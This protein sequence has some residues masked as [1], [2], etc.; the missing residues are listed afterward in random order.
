[1]SFRNTHVA[2][3]SLVA[4]ALA[5]CRVER[6]DAH[7]SKSSA[8]PVIVRPAAPVERP[9]TIAAS[10]TVG[11]RASIDLTFQVPGM[12]MAVGVEE[13]ER[14]AAGE[15]VAVIDPTEYALA[16]EQAK[17]AY[18]TASGEAQKARVMRAA[19]GSAPNEFD[20]VVAA[21]AMTKI[22]AAR[23][24]KRLYDTQL[25]SP[26][27]GVVARRNAKPGEIVTAGMPAF[28]IVDLDVVHV[29]VGVSEADIE[30]V[31][32]GAAASITV[33]AL[34]SARFAGK[35]RLVGVAADPATGK[36]AVEI[37][38]PNPEHHLKVGMSANATISTTATATSVTVPRVALSQGSKGEPQVFVYSEAEHRVH[39]RG[40][41]L[42]S[43][44][45]SEVD[46]ASGLSAGEMIVVGSRVKLSDGMVVTMANQ[47]I[48][49]TAQAPAGDAGRQDGTP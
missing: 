17:V 26:L 11:P 13:G 43:H 14:V 34:D 21:E 23:A 47:P 35:V 41:A 32:M 27:A 22:V 30:N 25:A 20:Q 2:A 37:A 40:V 16:F 3:L 4:F 48:V 44:R 31:H 49:I 24:E 5:A 6:A 39:V 42:G 10:G 28:T 18:L 46:V 36:Y 33:P 29:R 45:G 15:L 12:V 8:V 7:P 9:T 1:M 19:D 38:V